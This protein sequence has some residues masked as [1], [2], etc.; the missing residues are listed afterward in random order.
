MQYSCSVSDD[1]HKP[2]TSSVATA[3]QIMQTKL[4]PSVSTK[5]GKSSVLIFLL[6]ACQTNVNTFIFPNRT[7]QTDINKCFKF[8]PLTIISVIITA[9]AVDDDDYNYMNIYMIMKCLSL[10]PVSSFI[11][12]FIKSSM[13]FASFSLHSSFVFNVFGH[14]SC[15]CFEIGPVCTCSF[16]AIF[17]LFYFRCGKIMCFWS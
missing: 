7:K 12:L 14:S 16:F 5:D 8:Y 15:Y 10:N 9:A 17:I 4:K 11:F 3:S 6:T 2:C 13:F 1:K